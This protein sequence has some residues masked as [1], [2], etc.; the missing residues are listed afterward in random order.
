VA[1]ETYLQALRAYGY[2]LSVIG[3]DQEG[4]PPTDEEIIA[5]LGAEDHVDLLAE[6]G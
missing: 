3:R 1:P 2:R 4:A 6:P 5:P